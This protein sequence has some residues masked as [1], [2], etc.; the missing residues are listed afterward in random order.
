MNTIVI[1]LGVIV[2]V[3]IFILISY[4]SNNSTKL[5]TKSSLLL[6]NT[7]IPIKSALDTNRYAFGAW[8]C[9]NS[10]TFNNTTKT[11]FE[12]PGKI[13]LYLDANTPTLNA[14]IITI[15]GAKI[16]IVLTTNFPLQKWTYVTISA[17]NSYIDSY[18]DGKLVKSI[19]LEKL[20]NNHD[21]NDNNIYLGGKVPS[22]NDITVAKFYRWT[23]ALAPQDVWNEYMKGNGNMLGAFLSSYGLDIT[24]KKNSV[25]AATFN[26]F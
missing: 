22:L 17:D 7:I 5:V 20:Q 12:F 8:I 1:I 16:K 21:S 10:F 14:E 13:R 24:L 26:I 19:K 18:I 25:D 6:G 9:I 23:N 3:L 2:V 11:I 4:F 15:D